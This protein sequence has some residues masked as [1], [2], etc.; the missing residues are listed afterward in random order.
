METHLRLASIAVDR[1]DGT[2]PVSDRHDIV[3]RFNRDPNSVVLLLSIK[4]VTPFVRLSLIA[5]SG[6]AGLAVSD[7]TLQVRAFVDLNVFSF[8]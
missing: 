1:L 6:Y 4:F 2:T 8:K 3:S 7:S 5:D